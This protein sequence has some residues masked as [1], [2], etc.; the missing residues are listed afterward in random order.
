MRPATLLLA[1]ISLAA[2][3]EPTEVDPA[4]VTDAGGGQQSSCEEQELGAM[5]EHYVE[6]FVS[7]A[8]PSSCSQCHM[9]GVD[10]SMFA[11]DTPC[12]TMA[13]MIDQGAVNPEAPEQSRILQQIL[14]G[15][16]ASSAFSVGTEHAA[17]LQWLQYAAPCHDELCGQI[18]D[19]CG[20]GTGAPTTGRLPLG[21]C[22]EDDMLQQFWESVVVDRGRCITC[23]DN[24]QSPES[25]RFLEGL[26]NTNN[27]DDEAHRQR[28]MN[29]MYAI[30]TRGLIDREQ[31]LDSL[32]LTKPLLHGFRPY[33]VYGALEPIE[34]VPEGVGRGVH[35]GGAPKFQFECPGFDCTDGAIVDCRQD[36]ECVADGDCGE[37]QRCNEG[38]CRIRESVCDQTYVNYISFIQAYLAC[39][40]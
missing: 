11:Q 30:I 23:H 24:P 10:I 8:V 6:P 33:A 28:G 34:H 37:G 2:C 3:T 13:C 32:L 12:Q 25:P 14:L 18:E 35:H 17:I 26:H 19:P 31:P 1:V 29:A 27:F 38:Y 15:D 9:T 16:P 40:P 5:Y 36:Q 4:P 22:S 21:D 7:G 20:A 39:Q